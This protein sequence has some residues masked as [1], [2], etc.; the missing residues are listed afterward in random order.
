MMGK[1]LILCGTRA[2][3][4]LL[5]PAQMIRL[6]EFGMLI[7]KELWQGSGTYYEYEGYCLE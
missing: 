4:V 6:L 5:P 7:P 1:F 3:I 2:L